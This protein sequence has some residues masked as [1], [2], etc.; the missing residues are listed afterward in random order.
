MK[1]VEWHGTLDPHSQDTVPNVTSVVH[2]LF[3]FQETSNGQFLRFMNSTSWSL[4]N[5]TSTL[6]AVHQDLMGYALASPGIGVGHQ[7]LM[8]EDSIQALDVQI[9]RVLAGAV[10]VH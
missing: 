2:M 10:C 5:S 9:V 7:F 3:A 8:T 4:L 1:R 6:L